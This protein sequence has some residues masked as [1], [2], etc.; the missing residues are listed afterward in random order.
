MSHLSYLHI[1]HASAYT[2]SVIVYQPYCQHYFRYHIILDVTLIQISHYFRYHTISDI[3][4]SQISHYFRYHIISDITMLS[5]LILCLGSVS[6]LPAKR[7]LAYGDFTEE[8]VFLTP[9]DREEIQENNFLFEFP[10][11]EESFA[12]PDL[13]R[14]ERDGG[15]HHHPM[16]QG[17]RRRGGRQN[18]RL[19]QNRRQRPQQNQ[20][21]TQQV[22]REQG[23]QEDRRGRQSGATGLAL[24]VVNNTPTQDGS[25]DFKYDRE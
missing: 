6:S 21:R 12:G 10:Q 15:S 11:L 25:Y 8:E 14:G 3:T 22:F 2:V 4:L 24:G 5:L 1:Y 23:V 13:V 19:Q 20:R 9:A 7:Q 18:R 16:H 17:G